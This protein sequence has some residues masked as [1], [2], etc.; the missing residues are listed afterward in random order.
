MDCPF[1]IDPDSI[2][3]CHQ[4]QCARLNSWMNLPSCCSPGPQSLH[5]ALTNENHY[6]LC[7]KP[8]RSGGT[9][10]YVPFRTQRICFVLGVAPLAIIPMHATLPQITLTAQSLLTGRTGDLLTKPG[11][12]FAS[13]LMS[14]ASAWT[15]LQP[16]VPTPAP[17]A[18]TPHMA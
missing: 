10:Q 8:D 13:S 16:M 12:Q 17:S 15:P 18:V 6:A 3:Y 9:Y 7:D 4:F 5:S 14:K 1:I 11:C 2:T